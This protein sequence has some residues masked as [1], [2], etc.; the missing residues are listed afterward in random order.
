MSAGLRQARLWL[1][2]HFGEYTPENV[3][4]TVQADECILRLD[5]QHYQLA[6][7]EYLQ[8]EENDRR[9]ALVRRL[10]RAMAPEPGFKGSPFEVRGSDGWKYDFARRKVGSVLVVE[11]TING[12]YQCEPVK[13]EVKHISDEDRQAA[14]KRAKQALKEAEEVVTQRTCIEYN[15]EPKPFHLEEPSNI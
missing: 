2:T 13:Y 8:E 15:C 11:A 3:S 5:F 12:R 10:F 6:E 7:R 4:L 14:I 9:R 1:E